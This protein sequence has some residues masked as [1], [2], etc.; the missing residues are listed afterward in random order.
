METQTNKIPL[1]RFPEFKEGWEVKSLGKLSDRVTTKNKENNSNVCTISAQSGLISQLEYFNKSVSAKNITDYYLLNKNDFAYN[2]SYS[3]GYPMGAIKRL[4]RYE[5][6]VVSTLYI[7]FKNNDFFDNSFAEQYYETG[8]QNREIKK[9]AQEGARNHGLLNIALN[10]F[11]SIPI[12]L[13]TLPEQ[14]KIA[15]FFSIIDQKLTQLQEKKTALELYK[16]GMMQQLFCPH[17]DSDDLDD[18]QD[19]TKD[20]QEKNQ[21]NQEN[22]KKSKFRLRFKDDNGKGFPEWEE[23]KLGEVCEFSKGKGIS[24]KDI[25]ENGKSECIRYGEL[26]THYKEVIS[27]IISKTNIES[28]NLVFSKG[29]DVIIPASGEDR[30]DIATASCIINSGIAIGGDLNII[31]SNNNGI[32]LSYYLNSV[33]KIEI[34]NLAQGVSVV[35]LYSSQ[36]SPLSINLPTLPEQTKIANFLSKIDDKIS[37][38]TEKIEQTKEYKKGLLQKMFV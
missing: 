13:P 28:K 1:V 27:E 16:K 29:N 4:K 19:F 22:Q 6:G 5:K 33:K 36:L 37:T 31:R 12:T 24:K 26:Y 14:K 38:V 17:Y 30:L 3:K 35:H 7:C 10:D 32:F 11:F 8:N 18:E 23:K 34:A 9:V 25:S 2:K 20:S 15:H 21:G